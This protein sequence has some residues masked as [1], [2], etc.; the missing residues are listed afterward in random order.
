MVNQVE[1]PPSP[2]LSVVIPAYNEEQRLRPTL[3]RVHRYL[4]RQPYDFEILVVDNASTDGTRKLVE[5]FAQSAPQ[6]RLLEEPRRGKGAAVRRGLLAAA[7]RLVFFTDADLSTPIEELGKF[8]PEFGEC[9]V[10]IGSRKRPGAE[11]VYPQPWHRRFMGQVFTVLANF[12]LGLHLTDFTCGFKGF[13]REAAQVVFSRQRVED[14]SFDAEILFL[15]RRLGFR[16]KEVPVRWA[17]SRASKVRLWRDAVHS[18][19]GL[20]RIRLNGWLGRYR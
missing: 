17:D 14:W 8:Q 20:G 6:V 15:V 7:G 18:F 4:S 5:E 13:R 1:M 10:V 3:E 16:L 2:D 11:V 12:I 19:V 9:D